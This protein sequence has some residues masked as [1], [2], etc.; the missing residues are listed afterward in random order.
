L[1][2]GIGSF[3][4][5]WLFGIAFT[6]IVIQQKRI[7]FVSG[8]HNANNLLLALVFLDLSDASKEEF[9]WSINWTEFSLHIAALLLLIGLVY[10][11]L[12]KKE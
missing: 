8:A 6:I 12:S 9:S 2:Y 10:R 3:L 1:G 4:S 5:S 11:F 7:E